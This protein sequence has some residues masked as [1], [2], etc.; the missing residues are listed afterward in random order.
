MMEEPMRDEDGTPEAFPPARPLEWG[1]PGD[2]RPA[3]PQVPPAPP[4]RRRRRWLLGA[5]A[6]LVA[7]AVGGT[8]LVVSLRTGTETAPPV[9]PAAVD[10]QQAEQ[11]AP[12]SSVAEMVERVLP[13]VVNVRVTSVAVGPSGPEQSRGEG[14]GVVIDRNGII[15]TNNHVIAGALEV[16]VVFTDGR[17]AME[18][19]VIGADP[20]HDLAVVKVDAADLHPITV[21]QSGDLKLGDQVVAIGFPL[22]LGGP[23]VTEGIVSGLNRTVRVQ[24][25]SGIERLVGLLQTDAAINPGNSGGPLVNA[26]GQLVGINTAGVQAGAAE[27]IGFAIAIDEAMPIVR[28]I[29]SQPPER[30]AWLGVSAV[31][32]DSAAVAA[33]LGVPTDVR[34]AAIVAVFPDSPAEGADIREGDVIVG[35]NGEAIR[36]SEDL[37]RVLGDLEPGD[38]VEIELVNQAGSRSVEAELAQRPAGL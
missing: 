8:A 31:T 28:Q 1:P 22:D 23:T 6:A 4:P 17:P 30:R 13:S 11:E 5:I 2:S 25:Q 37:S 26:L 7:L 27:N 34:G 24:A 19:T 33:Q 36:S 35:V 18:G 32:V 15:L 21:G 29:M 14:S 10:I 38:A 12:H 3:I 9:R 20:Q 16:E